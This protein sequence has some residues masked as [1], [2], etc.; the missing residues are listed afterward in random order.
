M[1]SISTKPTACFGETSL[2]RQRFRSAVVIAIALLYLVLNTAVA[3]VPAQSTAAEASQPHGPM[4]M[5]AHH[6]AVAAEAPCPDERHCVE[7]Q[8]CKMQMTC[9]SGFSCSMMSSAF[10][11]A[12]GLALPSSDYRYAWPVDD[13]G[14]G[15]HSS[16]DPPPPRR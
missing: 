8:A 15:L 11:L 5:A 14:S 10:G 9:G 2:F 16:I 3:F 12:A 1:H 13:S 6:A 7:D 4:A